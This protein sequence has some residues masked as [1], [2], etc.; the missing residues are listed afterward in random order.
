MTEGK[1]TSSSRSPPIWVSISAEITSRRPRPRRGRRHGAVKG[2]GHRNHLHPPRHLL[3]G[4][5]GG[6]GGTRWAGSRR[7]T[8][9]PSAGCPAPCTLHPCTL[10]PAPCTLGSCTLHSASYTPAPCILHP[11]TLHPAPCTLH[12]VPC[13]PGPRAGCACFPHKY[14]KL[15]KLSVCLTPWSVPCLFLP[16]SSSPAP[17]GCVTVP[18]SSV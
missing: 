6:T 5:A 4:W 10:H 18:L 2:P 15:G 14:G 13:T 9:H 3:A 12:P 16:S 17:L 8:R 7:T 1:L 11:C